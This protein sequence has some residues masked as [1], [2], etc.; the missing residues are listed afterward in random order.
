MFHLGRG[1]CDEWDKGNSLGEPEN[2]HSEQACLEGVKT[3]KRILNLSVKSTSMKIT[4][5][6]FFV[7]LN[8]YTFFVQTARHPEMEEEDPASGDDGTRQGKCASY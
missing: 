3:I 2:D 4:V 1:V 8:Y 6:I 7:P 5:C